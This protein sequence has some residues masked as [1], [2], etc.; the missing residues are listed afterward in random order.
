MSET[1]LE[2][3]ARYTRQ[4]AEDAFAEIV[5]RHLDLVYSAALR[6]V[7]SSHLAEEVAQTVFL[8]LAQHAQEFSPSTVV[9][10]WLYQVTRRHAIDVVR[11]EARRQLREQIATKMNATDSA[12]AGW[13][14]I[15]PLLDEAMQALEET[16]RSA[17][18][19][20]FFANKSLREVGETLG[21]SDDAAQKRV[22]R[23][24]E[25]LR[26]FLAQRGVMVGAG[27]L[28]I[29]L[30]S[31]AVQAAPAGLASAVFTSAFAGAAASATASSASLS[32][33]TQ[34]L[35]MTTTQKALVV[36]T[37]V[38]AVGVSVY[39]VRQNAALRA[40]NLALEQEHIPLAEQVQQLKQ[41]R[42]RATNRV[43]AL[44]EEVAKSKRNPA[45]LLKLRGEVGS[46]IRENRAAGEKSALN[47]ITSD[48]ASRNA[49]RETQKLGMSAVY[50][51]LAKRL[52]FKPE[53]TGKFNDLLADSVMDNIDLITQALRDGK[54][55]SEVSQLFA[56]A[57]AELQGKIKS[58]LGD[59]ALAQYND[60]SQNLLSTLSAAQFAPSLSG[61]GPA[62][63]EK[64]RQLREAMQTETAAALKAAG[65]PAD[66]QVVPMLNFANIAS[67]S[68]AE[69]S[70]HLLE[71]IYANVATRGASFLSAEE[72]T[73]FE[74]FRTAA[75][76]N[77][78]SALVMN[79][80]LMAPLSK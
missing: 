8:K 50:G 70:L 57:D 23:A 39:E 77:S 46:L 52:N 44:T 76:N 69:Q 9:P 20:R 11:H 71:S 34:T 13:E 18:L 3:L 60:Y 30:S 65:L 29:V 73:K 41:E 53:V 56:S 74:A 36:L 31:H 68:M 51:E 35:A 62:R 27:G 21:T 33:T 17:I 14:Q 75:L 19:L 80:K 16:D 6:Q 26:E 10:A 12:E 54:S 7:R 28:G 58:L 5:R 1:D 24:I 43:A 66:Y 25:R 79:R 38:A 67:E 2:L 61:E 4:E 42:D 64:Q 63:Q 48:P 59:E 32:A 45:E 37:L 49:M 78:R 40:R 22:S 55:Q 15:E 47:K 72:L